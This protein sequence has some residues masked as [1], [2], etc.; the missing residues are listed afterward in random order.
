MRWSLPVWPIP[1]ANGA[2]TL[3]FAHLVELMMA[4]T[5]WA[6][7][8]LA[9]LNGGILVQTT[10]PNRSNSGLLFSGLLANTLNGGPVVNPTTVIPL[11]PDI[12]A[13]FDR[14][15]LMEATSG[16]LFEQFLITGIGGKPM[17]ALYESQI[18]EYLVSHPEHQ[19]TI[20]QDVRIV[21]PQP[22]VWA[23]HPFVARNDDGDRLLDAL[24]DPDIQRLAWE[25]H[26]QRPGVPK[27]DIDP[28]AMPVPG[29]LPEI[30]SVTSMPSLETMNL[31]LAAISGTLPTATPASTIAPFAPIVTLALLARVAS[32]I[33]GRPRHSLDWRRTM[34][35]LKPG[36]ILARRV[37]LVMVLV[38]LLSPGAIAAQAVIRCE[39]H[40]DG[41]VRRANRRA[42][43]S[44]SDPRD[45]PRSRR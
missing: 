29:I 24:K 9:Q 38:G 7:I 16:S 27:F 5:T 36:R 22:T 33:R 25:K 17:V 8:G 4:H 21:Y 37:C 14:L 43:R 11:L 1:L 41:A 20:A 32:A 28:D 39:R 44:G 15:G 12:Q 45:R 23:T 19:Q 10:D 40:L 35:T 13:Y 26:G 31:I 30:T 3:D 34:F 2:Y 6:Q 42:D 18:M